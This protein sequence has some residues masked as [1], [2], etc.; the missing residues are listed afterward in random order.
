M[1]RE[2]WARY[3][4]SELYSKAAI[5][6]RRHDQERQPIKRIG[7]KQLLT[8]VTNEIVLREI[9]NMRTLELRAA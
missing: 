6:L 4:N 9:E 3:S 8:E 2:T 7:W 1:S 5:F